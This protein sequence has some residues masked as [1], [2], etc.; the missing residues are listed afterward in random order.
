MGPR[1][2]IERSY[3][4]R[5]QAVC[6]LNPVCQDDCEQAH[7]KGEGS[8]AGRDNSPEPPKGLRWMRIHSSIM[9]YGGIGVNR[10]ILEIGVIDRSRIFNYYGVILILE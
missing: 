7:K 1:I 4:T 2:K 6:Q 3:R 9:S 8:P 5:N 10:N